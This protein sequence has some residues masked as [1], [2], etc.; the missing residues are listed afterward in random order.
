A[1]RADGVD[2]LETLG[3]AL[4][5]PVL[6]PHKAFPLL[7]LAIPK[8]WG[9]ELWYTGIEARGVCATGDGARSVPLPWLLAALPERFGG[10]RA[11]V[12]M[13][14]LDPLPEPVRGD[15]YFELHDEKEELYLV[16][17]IDDDAWP[18]GV[19]AVRMGFDR[20]RLAALGDTGLRRAFADAVAAY[21]PVRERIDAHLDAGRD[22][23][24]IARDAP[25]DGATAAR[26]E[27]DLP[28][29]LVDRERV[30]RAE[31]EALTA[32]RPLRVGDLVQVPRGVPHALQHGVRVM[33]FQ[34]PLYE[35][36]I[37]WFAQ[38][39]LTEPDRN[40]QEVIDRMQLLP[41]EP[42]APEAIPAPAGVHAERICACDAF[43]VLR[44]RMDPDSRY[45]PPP[46]GHAVLAGLTGDVALDD[47]HAG[48]GAALLIPGPALAGE[49]RAGADGA[50]CLLAVPATHGAP[51]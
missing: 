32:L 8:P 5:T 41:P 23:A 22:A 51:S 13:K 48:A 31:V 14:V 1:L 18:D 19:G 20:E 36:R 15:L 27:A 11:P 35:R 25:L 49:L 47:R 42:S 40:T 34:T 45:R 17:A 46:A 33:E 4:D 39:V 26:L 24:G 21:R 6:D 38:K 12:L 44:L 50:V 43:D 28:A 29:T 2:E 9:R 30:L 7:P 37:L 16:T 10:V 3:H